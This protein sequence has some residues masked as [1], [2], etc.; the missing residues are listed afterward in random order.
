MIQATSTP[1]PSQQQPQ[2]TQPHSP[3]MA[4]GYSRGRPKRESVNSGHTRTAASDAP[5]N[6]LKKKRPSCDS[7]S[8][9]FRFK[10]LSNKKKNSSSN[11]SARRSFKPLA[12]LDLVKTTPTQ[13]LQ[14]PLPQ[15]PPTLLHLPL[16]FLHL[17]QPKANRLR[18]RACHNHPHLLQHRPLHRLQ[19]PLRRAATT[20]RR[21]PNFSKNR[22][23]SFERGNR[24]LDAKRRS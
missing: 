22:F 14:Q 8:K 20:I 21:T 1:Q 13:P 18:A 6:R 17:L 3:L 7:S 16:T 24:K 12:H 23:R 2:Q 4:S 11:N 5:T 10:S 19:H 15:P 9:S